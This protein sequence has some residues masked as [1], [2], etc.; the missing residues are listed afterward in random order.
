MQYPRYL[1]IILFIELC[2]FSC[3]GA[4]SE[5]ADPVP[6][7]ELHTLEISAAVMLQN[8][9]DGD[10]ELKRLSEQ[11]KGE[12]GEE[13]ESLILRST[14]RAIAQ[15]SDYSVITQQVLKL[16]DTGLNTDVIRDQLRNKM[17]PLGPKI[18]RAIASR[19]RK[20]DSMVEGGNPLSD[21]SLQKLEERHRFSDLA[22]Q[23]LSSHSRNLALLDF[24]NKDIA[25]YLSGAVLER[26]E[27]LSGQIQIA[28]S[29]KSRAD[30]ASSHATDD[31]QL[32]N[33]GRA[34]QRKLNILTDSLRSTIDLMADNGIDSASY[35][36][37]LIRTT[38]ELTADI[39]KPE[40]LLG[41]I[42][43]WLDRSLI[44]VKKYST[45][46]LFKAMMLFGLLLGF[47]YLS[48][49]I[50]K[51]VRKG[52][53]RSKVPVSLL[54]EEMLVAMAV[55]VVF[56]LGILIA[57]SQ[58]GVSLAPVL[59]GLGVAGFII[60]FA[61]QDTLGNFASGLMILIYRPFD[62]G[63][64]IKTGSATGNVRSMNLVSTT[65]LTIDHQTL[66]IPNNKI[67]GDVINN[68]TAQKLRR[69]DMNFSVSYSENTARVDA[70]LNDILDQHPLVLNK[71]E[72]LVK[73]H[74]LGDSSVDFIVRPWVNTGDYWNVYWDITRA[75]KDRFD[76]ENIRIPF[77]Q[78]DVHLYQHEAAAKEV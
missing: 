15:L 31:I 20:M 2:I 12:V 22:Y 60:G 51:V 26:A 42:G 56:F 68:L 8:L 47:F 29:Q 62:V 6:V 36:Q 27:S 65:V 38:G 77:P 55:R 46:M 18:R 64:M 16:Q 73:L 14:Q 78:R 74:T 72:G 24:N 70:I 58:M 23:A 59:A 32:K 3:T 63:D 33:Q 53:H 7:K 34:A 11:L 13:K 17:L 44:F 43:N 48:R 40:I 45:E 66:V 28:S 21:N 37:L 54:M 41:L 39:L 71:P 50:G 25:V 76:E 75:V 57:L 69:V 67:W 1:L 10:A 19:E 52:L 49:F 5:K 35:R 4:A 9:A 30:S 61:L